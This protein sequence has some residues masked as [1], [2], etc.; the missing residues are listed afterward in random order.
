[1]RV[2][3]VVKIESL[4]PF[5]GAPTAVYLTC[6]FEFGEYCRFVHK[7]NL[8]IS[9]NKTIK[10][11]DII[12]PGFTMDRKIGL[13]LVGFNKIKRRC[14]VSLKQQAIRQRFLTREGYCRRCVFALCPSCWRHGPFSSRQSV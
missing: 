14:K 7:S 5:R 12:L 9:L 13:Y 2:D 4:H 8:K 1:M 11:P 6:P 10:K 3:G